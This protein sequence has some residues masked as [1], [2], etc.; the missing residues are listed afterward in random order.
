MGE[1]V[2]AKIYVN[3]VTAVAS[4]LKKIPKGI[5]GATIQL[6]FGDDWEGLSKTAVF[7][8]AVTKD[9]LI[10]GDIVTIPAECVEMSGHR[11]KVGFYGVADGTLAIPT[12]WADLGLI[13][14]AADPSGDTSTDPTLP[15]WAQLQAEVEDLQAEV[16]DLQEAGGTAGPQGPQGDPGPAGKDGQPGKDGKDGTDGKDGYTPVKGKDY[17]T[18]EDINGIVDSVINALPSAEGGSY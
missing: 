15:V 13:R 8:G 4:M 5:I 1:I 18:E 11:L 9:V 2:I 10:E 17:F 14:D 16:E 12:I 7:K 6:T 3:G